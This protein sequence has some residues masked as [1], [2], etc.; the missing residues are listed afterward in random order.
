M[1]H[2]ALAGNA[3]RRGPDRAEPAGGAGRDEVPAVEVPVA[4]AM[5]AGAAEAGEDALARDDVA[6]MTNEESGGHA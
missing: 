5:A 2:N 3:R 1:D 6:E 4:E